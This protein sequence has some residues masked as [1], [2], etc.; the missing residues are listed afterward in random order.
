[1][2]KSEFQ[3]LK[4]KSSAELE[5]EMNDSREKLR[6]LKFD[7][8]SGKVKETAALREIKKRIAK[9]LTLIN[10]KQRS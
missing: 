7:L 2:K 8:K 10:D 5:K 1:M 6:N 4:S 9:I 3:K